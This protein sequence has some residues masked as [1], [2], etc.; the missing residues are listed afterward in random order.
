[1]SFHNVFCIQN[2]TAWDYRGSSLYPK[3]FPPLRGLLE[4]C[5]KRRK[6]FRVSFEPPVIPCCVILNTKNIM[7]AH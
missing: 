7:K 1:M 4:L 6:A 2:D 3:C 5:S